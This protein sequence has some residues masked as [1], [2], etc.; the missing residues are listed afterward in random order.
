MVVVELGFAIS[1]EAHQETLGTELGFL[2]LQ[3]A[4]IAGTSG[5][6]QLSLEGLGQGIPDTPQGLDRSV[7][8][9]GVAI[10]CLHH[11]GDD[12]VHGQELVQ[13]GTGSLA[14]PAL[15]VPILPIKGLVGVQTI[16]VE[17][18][19]ATLPQHN[20]WGVLQ[21]GLADIAGHIGEPVLDNLVHKLLIR[22]LLGHS[23]EH[24]DQSVTE[25][26][27]WQQVAH[28]LGHVKLVLHHTHSTL[29]CLR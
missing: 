12:H 19:L 14:A 6:P 4:S 28:H 8:N 13:H 22:H 27:K 29:L 1:T 10:A 15:V 23:K 11:P 21:L 2:L 26:L 17:L 9:G 5:H 16:P 18:A 7:L 20:P 3:K 24:H 25:D